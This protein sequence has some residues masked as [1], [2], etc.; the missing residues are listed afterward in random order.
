MLLVILILI[1]YL[2]SFPGSKTSD[3]IGEMELDEKVFNG[4]PNGWSK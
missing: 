4:M 3:I 2:S 1:D